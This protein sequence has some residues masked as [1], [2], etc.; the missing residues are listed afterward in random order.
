MKKQFL[1]L[2]EVI[3]VL[4][5]KG[6]KRLNKNTSNKT[7]TDENGR[8]A[9]WYR[10]LNIRPPK[11]LEEQESEIDED[12]FMKLND[13]ELEFKFLATIID[14]SEF[15]M[16]TN[17]E[18][19]FGSTITLK[20]L[21]TIKVEED[22]DDVYGQILYNERGWFERFKDDLRSWYYNLRASLRLS[23]KKKIKTEEN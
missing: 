23:P 12:G 17:D 1:L 16:A 13:D 6:E 14:S 3:T 11:Y 15:L 10:E 8:D 7:A 9:E 19:G 18:E 21:F 4:N 2:T 20:N 5:E 22:I